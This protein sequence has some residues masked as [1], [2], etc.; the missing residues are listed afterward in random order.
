[1]NE[2]QKY[3]S[4]YGEKEIQDS[5]SVDSYALEWSWLN[6]LKENVRGKMMTERCYNAMLAKQ[7]TAYSVNC[8]SLGKVIYPGKRQDWEGK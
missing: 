6:S 8:K 1:M 2:C 3:G 7:S 4:F 5:F